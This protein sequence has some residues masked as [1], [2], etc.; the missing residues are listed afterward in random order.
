MDKR[1]IISFILMFFCIVSAHANGPISQYDLSKFARVE[2]EKTERSYYGVSPINIW[3]NGNS[4]KICNLISTAKEDIYLH[5]LYQ[6]DPK[7]TYTNDNLIRYI[8]KISKNDANGVDCSQPQRF[9]VPN[10]GFKL[11]RLSDNFNL[12]P[13]ESFFKLNPKIDSSPFI[14]IIDGKEKKKNDASFM[15]WLIDIYMPE[16]L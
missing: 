16:D 11:F 8:I 7:K 3:A 4:R 6:A 1:Q 13:N 15:S 14:E 9:N 2:F 10:S 12:I 5:I